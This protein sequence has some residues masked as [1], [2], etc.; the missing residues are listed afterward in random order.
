MRR[1]EVE[2]PTHKVGIKLLNDEQMMNVLPSYRNLLERIENHR[3]QISKLKEKRLRH[4]QYNMMYDNVFSIFGNR[5]TGKTSVA[6][7]LQEK[8]RENV[9]Y[10]YDVVLP[11]IIPEVIPSDCSALG[12]LLE[13]VGEKILELFADNKKSTVDD[14]DG[15]FW[16][17]CKYKE[18]GRE[19]DFLRKRFEELEELYYSVKYNPSSETSYTLAVG[20]S[21]RQAQNYYKLSRKITEFWDCLI[22]AIRDKKALENRNLSNDNVPPLIY[23]IFDDVDLAPEKVDELMSIIIKYLSH[24]NIIVI[25]T[26]DEEMVLEVIE[27]NLD[28]NIGRIP[29]EW[30]HYLNKQQSWR[31]DTF[32]RNGIDSDRS[33]L[34]S[35]MARRYLGKV[36]PTSTRYY[37]RLFE[38]AE[39][40]WRFS[41]DDQQ[42]LGNAVVKLVDQML[43]KIGLNKNNF[44]KVDDAELNFYLNFFGNTSRQ[45]GNAFL[46]VK[47]FIEECTK[48]LNRRKK[49]LD[50]KEL[51]RLYELCRHF[52][53][54]AITANHTLAETL[55]DVE[56]VVHEVF[57][58]EHNNWKLYIDYAYLRNLLSKLLEREKK[59]NV[60]RTTLQL[61]SLLFFVENVLVIIDCWALNGVT[62]RKRIHGIAGMSQFI[63]EQVF[64]GKQK[65]RVDWRAE[66]FFLH[67]GTTLN[68]ICYLAKNVDG[69]EEFDKEYLYD[70]LDYP[71][72]EDDIGEGALLKALEKSKDWLR[73]IS[74]TLSAVY[75]NLY[76]IGKKE[77]A[78]CLVYAERR[79]LCKY[80]RII[81]SI[82]LPDIQKCLRWFDLK[83]T[84]E[85]ELKI[86][87][88]ISKEKYESTDY[89]K[90]SKDLH[91]IFCEE[92]RKELHERLLEEYIEEKDINEIDINEI[93]S[94]TFWKDY[95]TKWN[96]EYQNNNTIPLSRII[97]EINK[98]CEQDTLETLLRKFPDKLAKAIAERVEKDVD[99]DSLLLILTVLQNFITKW[100]QRGRYVEFEDM[101]LFFKQADDIASQNEG[102]VDIVNVSDHIREF[103]SDSKIDLERVNEE[104]SWS[105]IDRTI[106]TELKTSLQN[107]CT[108]LDAEKDI[109]KNSKHSIEMKLE[110]LSKGF[111]ISIELE[112][113]VGFKDAVMIGVAV[114]LMKQIQELYL[115]QTVVQKYK[116]GY[117]NSSVR[118]EKVKVKKSKVG[119]DDTDK[120]SYYYAMFLSMKQLLKK[121]NLD[122][123]EEMD[124][125][126][127]FIYRAFSENRVQYLTKLINEARNESNS[128]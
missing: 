109:P 56:G 65:F 125:L 35:K 107:I 39:E 18:Q 36:M 27:N 40:K 9:D 31:K 105:L 2:M 101:G 54:I 115:Y 7:T 28:K 78:N 21:A 108:L 91:N 90:Y 43:K 103:F 32:G 41:I 73:E 118:L 84:A 61:Y 29:K 3:R 69:V 117:G 60:I 83:E 66:I 72:E 49:G 88:R 16:R 15:D 106:Y 14:R 86:L 112:D 67:Y 98:Q 92:M 77:I 97:N 89:D 57:W 122:S 124:T 99:K 48:L 127:N 126:K 10:S 121:E 13:I 100:D 123:I 58:M 20:N 47:E 19:Y 52:L 119:M 24:P 93:D 26:A 120:N 5:G 104:K 80:Q 30:R 68:R 17:K 85:K 113:Q 11:I 81:E 64:Q 74:G 25:T 33:D 96:E 38:T 128:N 110:R 50:E 75:G 42:Q 76:L 59:E 4:Y 116:L 94:D 22:E 63:C 95:E 46:G 53:Q 12:W 111:D 102:F 45:I 70:F 44:L 51:E 82:L 79:S 55:G 71:Y 37:L 8:F 62:G 87:K 114:Q 23:F 34:I 6:F 1:E